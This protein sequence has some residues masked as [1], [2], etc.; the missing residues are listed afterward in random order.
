MYIKNI[1]IGARSPATSKAYGLD[2]FN[3]LASTPHGNSDGNTKIYQG[4]ESKESFNNIDPEF[5]PFSNVG[6]ILSRA[7]SDSNSSL[8]GPSSV[9]YTRGT[10]DLLSFTSASFGDDSD[11]Y[12]DARRDSSFLNGGINDNPLAR[13]HNNT[14]N[15]DDNTTTPL[16]ASATP[17]SPLSAG[18]QSSVEDKKL[19]AKK[20]WHKAMVKVQATRAFTAPVCAD[21]ES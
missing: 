3:P 17:I 13:N 6:P 16:P 11:I 14:D 10:S 9:D 15:N 5:D 4:L 20:R 19:S 1:Y 7:H 2:S 18:S 21:G 8:Y 12:H